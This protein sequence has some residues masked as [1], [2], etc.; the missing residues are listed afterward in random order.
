MNIRFFKIFCVV[1]AFHFLYQTPIFSQFRTKEIAGFKQ[2]FNLFVLTN[3]ATFGKYCSLREFTKGNIVK[4]SQNEID[5]LQTV[6]LLGNAFN[7]ME[8]ISKTDSTFRYE[9][10]KYPKGF[11][12][13]YKIAFFF[14]DNEIIIYRDRIYGVGT[15]DELSKERPYNYGLLIGLK[16]IDVDEQ[17]KYLKLIKNYCQVNELYYEIHKK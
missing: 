2:D 15:G 6:M 13:E 16:I 11:S 3:E 9:I 1:C 7:L 12:V 10:L 17:K 5:S 14:S 8:Y 4:A